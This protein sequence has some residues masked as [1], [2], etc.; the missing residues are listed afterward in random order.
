MD[1]DHLGEREHRDAAA[2]SFSSHFD[3]RP[4]HPQVGRVESDDAPSAV[5]LDLEAD[6]PSKGAAFAGVDFDLDVDSTRADPRVEAV[7]FSSLG[8]GAGIVPLQL[9]WR[10]GLEPSNLPTRAR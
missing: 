4:C 7:F 3:A 1:F 9:E 8:Q 5:E 2:L 10:S 6:L